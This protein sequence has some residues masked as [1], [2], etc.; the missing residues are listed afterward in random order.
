[1]RIFTFLAIIIFL[2]CVSSAPAKEVSLPSKTLVVYNSND[3]D[4]VELAKYYAA[5]RKI[6]DDQVLGLK[7]TTESEEISRDEYDVTIA[8][9]LREAFSENNWWELSDNRLAPPAVVKNKIRYVALIRGIPLKVREK[10]SYPGDKPDPSTPYGPVNGC[11]VDSE[12][13]VLGKLT[14]QISGPLNN[15]YY[16]NYDRFDSVELPQYMLVCRLD[17]PS[18]DDVKR[19]ID[20]SLRAEKVG[21]WGWVFLDARGTEL[22]G[23]KQG[24]DWIKNA[25]IHFRK[26]GFPTFLDTTEPILPTGLPMP[27]TA[28]YLGWYSADL[29]GAFAGN[30]VRFVPGAIACH[31]HSFSA[32]TL[33]SRTVGWC[34]PLISV[35]ADAVMGNVYEPYLA[36]TADLD[37]FSERLLRG[38]TFAES[39]W[40]SLK[41]MSWMS[42]AVGDPL[43]RPYA[44]LNN[45]EINFGGD[46]E[47][48]RRSAVKNIIDLNKGFTAEAWAQRKLAQS[49]TEAA[50]YLFQQ[51]LKKYR[52]PDSI[53][54]VAWS[55]SEFLIQ[56]GRKD[57]AVN[58]LKQTEAK[59]RGNSGSGFLMTR[60]LELDPPKPILAP[61]SATEVRPAII[62][63]KK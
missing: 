49:D 30:G 48:F 8:T 39:A 16:H 56:K 15:P 10:T 41:T 25:G 37:I 36:L 20:E 12:I 26:W 1:M 19:M 13:A 9:P 23:Y 42:V 11:S 40:A 2:G 22:P 51:A 47:I 5:R 52:E 18:P 14:N 35:G 4:S 28:I 34:G 54:R 46:F 61:E 33:R 24:D 27:R 29:A 32:S 58:L 60:V 44:V 59:I 21:L 53:A 6:P 50:E 43:Y 57:A 31:I 55:Y 7:C 3:P 45:P 38:F 62:P 17:G 63:P